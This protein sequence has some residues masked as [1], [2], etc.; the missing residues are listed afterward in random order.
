ML[1]GM[2][3]TRRSFLRS[4][5][6][7]PAAALAQESALAKVTVTGLETFR[8]QVNR[9]GDWIIP[10]LQ[11]S[12]GVTGIGDASQ[13]QNDQ[14]ML[15]FLS[16]FFSALKGRSVS[17]IEYLRNVGMAEAQRSGMPA[18]VAMSALE[19]C[20][21]DISGKVL[22]VPVSSFFGGSINSHI[23]PYANI[24]RSTDPRT[25]EGFAAMARRAVEAGFDAVKLAPF[26]EMPRNLSDGNVIEDFTKRGIECA[27]AVREAIGPKVDLLIDVHSHLDVPRGRELVERMQPLNLFWIEEVTPANPVENL[28]AVRRASK[29]RTAGGESILGVKGFYPYIRGEA[30]DVV[31]PDPKY[32][33][34]LLE[35]KK[36]AAMAEGAGLLASPHGPASPVGTLAAAHVCAT[37]PNFL[38]LEFS[39]GEVPWRAEL[40]EPAEQIVGGG[41]PLSGRPGFGISLN[42]RTARKYAVV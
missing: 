24:N 18:A 22:G 29:I 14:R 33:G 31:M 13:S 25:P 8:V 3:A 9:R 10:R 37:L 27:R 40:I 2:H 6:A 5:S 38:I 32:C 20:L 30:V 1:A 28:A 35:L 19:Q 4:L 15:A 11:T 41:L 34:G 17:D 23:R 21:W 36:I 26:D 16:Q 39:Y 42:E 12:A 7:L